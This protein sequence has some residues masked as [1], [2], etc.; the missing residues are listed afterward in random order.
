MTRELRR[1]AANDLGGRLFVRGVG[2]GEQEAHGNRLDTLGDERADRL[3]HIVGIQWL[4]HLA[5]GV[6]ALADLVNALAGEQHLRARAG[7]C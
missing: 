6:E 1:D 3:D 5:L 7:R 2:V 4:D